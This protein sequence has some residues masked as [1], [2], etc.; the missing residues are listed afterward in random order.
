M[1]SIGIGL[2]QIGYCIAVADHGSTAAA[3]R[4]LNVSQPS[5]SLAVT[6]LEEVCGQ[7]LF[8]RS[9]T[10]GMQPTGFGLRKLAELRN[11][12]AQARAVLSGEGAA[13]LELSLGVFSSLG[14]RYVPALIRLF[15]ERHPN[16][17]VR[18]HE[19]DLESQ[20]RWLENGQTDLALIYDFHLPGDVIVTPIRN[21]SPYLLVPESHRLAS[22]SST[23]LT[24]IAEEPL[25]LVNLPHSRGYFL[26]LLA[27]QQVAPRIA[28]ETA[29]TEMLRSMV[30]NNLGVGLLATELPYRTAYDGRKVVHLEID[31]AVP[32]HR[33]ALARSATLPQTWIAAEFEAFASAYFAMTNSQA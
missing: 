17:S 2:R 9:S 12:R 4:A 11:L 22:R 31:G 28:Q 6:R 19:G 20:Y 32:P 27:L 23:A 30:A 7:Q 24:E 21:V 33:I 8:T 18:L 5:I 25:I 13:P 15:G 3:A 26:S 10:R 16:L 29:S 14:P 1:D